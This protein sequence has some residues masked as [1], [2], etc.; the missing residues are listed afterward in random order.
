MLPSEAAPE[1]G[2]GSRAVFGGAQ[3]WKL[4]LALEDIVAVNHL[5]LTDFFKETNQLTS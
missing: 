3:S 2:G 4:C 1:A 5:W